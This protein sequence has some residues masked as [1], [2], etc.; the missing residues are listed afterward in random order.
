MTNI[1]IYSKDNCGYCDMAVKL[2][3]MN[4]LEYTLKK[5]DK[6][7]T[8]EELLEKFPRAKTFPVVTINGGV[9]GGFTEFKTYVTNRHSN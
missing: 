1:E 6:D 4:K 5:L 9:I 2:A 8:R 7:F 3:D